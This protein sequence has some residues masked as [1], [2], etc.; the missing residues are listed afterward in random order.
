MKIFVDES[1]NFIQRGDRSSVSAVGALVITERQLPLVERRYAQLRPLLPKDRKGEVK[2]CDLSEND[3]ARVVELARRSGLIYEVAVIDRLPNDFAAVEEHRKTYTEG[4]TE[5]LTDRHHPEFIASSHA[6]KHRLEQMP[7][8]LYV[9]SVATFEVLWKILTK[10]IVYYSQREPESLGRF[11]WVVDAKDRKRTSWED[12]WSK[13]VRPHMQTRSW[14]KPLEGFDGGDY[15]HLAFKEMDIPADIRKAFPLVNE[16][17]G[18]GFDAFGDI[19]FSFEISTGLEL[20]DVL[21]NCVRRALAGHLEE[22][23]WSGLS[24]IMIN[25]QEPTC[26]RPIAFVSERRAVRPEVAAVLLKLG[27]GGRSMFTEK[28]LRK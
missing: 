8:Q 2:G 3:V 19:E 11:H 24:S 22:R 14:E 20:V 5:N 6:L 4:L 18:W 9:Q 12:W 27:S 16:E 10:A 17:R 15:S 13:V 25:H 21:T 7:E 1:S 23:G 26:I 28:V